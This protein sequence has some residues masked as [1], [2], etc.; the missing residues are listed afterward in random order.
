VVA[1]LTSLHINRIVMQGTGALGEPAEVLATG[2]ERQ[3]QGQQGQPQG[4]AQQQVQELGRHQQQLS[5][6]RPQMMRMKTSS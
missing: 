1:L 5:W 6:S 2:Q 3:R 4:Y